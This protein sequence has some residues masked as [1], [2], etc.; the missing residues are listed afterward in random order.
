MATL[1]AVADVETLLAEPQVITLPTRVGTEVT[2]IE[3]EEA[4]AYLRRE[5][6]IPYTNFNVYEV[7]LEG[8]GTN[9]EIWTDPVTGLEHLVLVDP[10]RDDVFEVSGEVLGLP[11]R[12]EPSEDRHYV[13]ERVR[14]MLGLPQD[15]GVYTA[16]G[17]ARA[18]PTDPSL[19]TH[20]LDRKLLGHI[21]AKKEEAAALGSIAA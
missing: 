13:R 19:T 18:H 14:L 8:E 4:M 7:G 16:F 12:G 6:G 1:P 5:M 15:S 11:F 20:Y 17:L 3:F 10:H 21:Q 9:G 2:Q